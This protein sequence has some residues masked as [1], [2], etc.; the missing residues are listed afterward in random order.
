MTS[1][2]LR[3]DYDLITSAP[4][5][6]WAAESPTL[7]PDNSDQLDMLVLPATMLQSH[8]THTLHTQVQA[9]ACWGPSLCDPRVAVG[10][11]FGHL[12]QHPCKH[13]GQQ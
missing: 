7:H 5:G 4:A 2:P 10:S 1:H 12:L 3:T 8:G 6:M 11:V 13:M 9:G